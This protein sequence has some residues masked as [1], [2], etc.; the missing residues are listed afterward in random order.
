MLSMESLVRFDAAAPSDPIPIP[1]TTTPTTKLLSSSSVEG[2]ALG[3]E[4]LR[5][6]DPE[7]HRCAQT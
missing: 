7:M 6:L 3:L 2:P 1:Q 5:E 4:D